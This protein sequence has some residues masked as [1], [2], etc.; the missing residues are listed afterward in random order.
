MVHW[1]KRYLPS[2][3]LEAMSDIGLILVPVKAQLEYVVADT[4]VLR[5]LQLVC[6]SEEAVGLFSVWRF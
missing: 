6:L 3:N 1:S 4:L 2:S 5:S